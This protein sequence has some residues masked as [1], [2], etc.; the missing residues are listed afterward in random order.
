LFASFTIS[1]KF[2]KISWHRLIGTFVA[3]NRRYLKSWVGNFPEGHSERNKDKPNIAV[4]SLVLG[5]LRS[6]MSVFLRYVSSEW[7]LFVRCLRYVASL[8]ASM[9]TPPATLSTNKSSF[10]SF[11]P[12]TLLG[13]SRILAAAH[14]YQQETRG[15]I[16]ASSDD[17]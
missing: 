14:V 11:Q 5:P 12:Y 9:S 10:L 17:C 16:A 7:V 6:R 8:V 2:S 1:F 4:T 15:T 3:C 13:R